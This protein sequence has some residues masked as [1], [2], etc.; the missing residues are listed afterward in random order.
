MSGLINL[1]DIRCGISILDKAYFDANIKPISDLDYDYI[2]QLVK[3]RKIASDKIKHMP[4]VSHIG[5]VGS[6]SKG[7]SIAALNQ[8]LLKMKALF[9]GEEIICI[10]P[11]IDG[12]SISAIYNN[13]ELI[14]VSTRGSGR[15]GCDITAAIKGISLPSYATLPSGTFEFVGEA[16][17]K[18]R[19]FNNIN[20]E[21]LH[22]GLPPYNDPRSLVAASVKSNDA[23]LHSIIS[24][25]LYR[26][27]ASPC[28]ACG[29]QSSLVD[30][31]SA[32]S[33]PHIPISTTASINLLL[34]S[35]ITL[36]NNNLGIPIDG[37]VYKINSLDK[38]NSFTP[39][40]MPA[41]A[42]ALK[43]DLFCG[44]STVL[45]ISG[46]TAIVATIHINNVTVSRA[47]ISKST[48]AIGSRVSIALLGGT[49]P[50]LID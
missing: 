41:W 21:R 44:E 23:N 4:R 27:S 39:S 6:L 1:T 46:N 42:F 32:A 38:Q 7:Y 13:G 11:K 8:F 50:A 49:F 5:L 3:P 14:S 30:F 17:I 34:S 31:F 18:D 2:A 12:I 20:T 26:I 9:G 48:P 16:F 24:A 33:L 25:S 37:T 22:A 45:S 47:R 35:P 10:E 19:T 29:S 28:A 36:H 15:V 43:H 40:L